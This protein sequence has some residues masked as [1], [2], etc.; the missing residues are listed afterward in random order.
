MLNIEEYISN[1]Y[2]D[3][4]HYV[5]Q[6][7]RMCELKK[8][9]FD[10]SEWPDY[11]NIH[12]QQYYLL[13]YGFIYA[14]EY[15]RMYLNAMK[16]MQQF[17]DNTSILSLGCGSGID[18][19]SA[20]EASRELRIDVNRLE[21]YG[22]DKINWS[23]KIDSDETKKFKYINRD[24]LS[25]FRLIKK[26]PHNIFMFPKSIA[27]FTEEDFTGMCNS[28]ESKI[29]EKD[30]IC[31]MISLRA[32]DTAM[33]Y[34]ILRTGRIVAA[35]GKQGFKTKNNPTSYTLFKD[36]KKGIRAYDAEF[37]YPDQ[38]YQLL[39]ELNTKCESYIRNHQNCYSDCSTR[40]T[41]KPAFTPNIIR[42]QI[43]FFER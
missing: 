34:D 4:G 36:K 24:I 37:I 23:Y 10:L 30:Q 16:H 26:F 15:K 33:E 35:L 9:N 6:N 38:A 31:V 2:V 28:L 42:Y 41:R 43:L 19:W 21:Y 20:I 22:I 12:V 8:V 17:T 39:S 40:L 5:D 3:F 7:P 25:L 11:S 18:F 29:F 32:N 13:R 14:F 1:V 27:E